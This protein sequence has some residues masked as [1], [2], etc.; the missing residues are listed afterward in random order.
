METLTILSRDMTARLCCLFVFIALNLFPSLLISQPLAFDLLNNK[1]EIEIP[2]DLENGFIIVSVKLANTFPLKFI[3]DTGA[4]NTILFHKVY[5]DLL[6][7]Q[8][9]KKIKI[10]GADLSQDV[11]AHVA[12][13]VDLTLANRIYGTRDILVLEEEVL[14]VHSVMGTSIDGIIGG[15]FF[16]GLVIAIDYDKEKIKFIDP[17][18]FSPPNNGYAELPIE[19]ISNKP[20]LNST[21]YSTPKDHRTS[22]LLIDSGSAIPLLLHSNTD[23][24]LILPPNLMIGSLGKGL[25]GLILGFKGKIHKLTFNIFEFN[26]IITAFQDIDS[27]LVAQTK[28][29][30]NGLLG[31]DLLSRFDMMIDYFHAKLYLKPNKGY[32]KSFR[33]D[34]SGMIVFAL[35]QDFDQFIINA[36]IDS[37]PAHKAGLMKGDKILKIGCWKTKFWSLGRINALLSAQKRKKIRLVIERNG[38]KMKKSF[39]LADYFN[40]STADV[41]ESK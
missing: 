33:Y 34:R 8:L 5:A 28:L 4:E 20:Y 16:R 38:V 37:S 32:R 6:N 29:V 17:L 25:G 13:N 7:F 2:F 39:H 1:R 3:F 9:D 36:I 10:H 15:S 22:K 12:R 24:T 30:R 41:T 23:T 40:V 19:I 31:N 11:Y 35:G 21:T 18:K 14:E 26:N 27:S